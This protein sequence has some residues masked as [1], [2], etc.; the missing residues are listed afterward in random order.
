MIKKYPVVMIEWVD[1]HR[2]GGWRD[3]NEVIEILSEP[4]RMNCV[5]C[6]FLIHEDKA[7]ITVAL[8]IGNEQCA[9][10]MTIPRVAISRIKKIRK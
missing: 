4:K 2:L 8:N 10:A 3:T 9:D 6:G 5:T 7:S 1:S